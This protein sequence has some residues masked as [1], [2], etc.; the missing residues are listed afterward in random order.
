MGEYVEKTSVYYHNINGP[1]V[2]EMCH[3]IVQEARKE[4]KVTV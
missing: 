1:R 2:N 4:A 3:K